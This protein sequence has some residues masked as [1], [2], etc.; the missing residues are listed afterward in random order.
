MEAHAN[1]NRI[2]LHALESLDEQLGLFD[3]LA[4]ADQIDMLRIA[5]RD[6]RHL[7]EIFTNLVDAYLA[8][9]LD[10]IYR[11]LE[12]QATGQTARL[13]SFFSDELIDRRNQ[14]MVERMQVRLAEG[15]ALIAVGALRLPGEDGLLRLLERRGFSI[16]RMD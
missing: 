2:A 6:S 4:P 16:Q 13:Q 15:N 8:R 5:V 3:R 1:A 11:L 14:R 7:D 10:A 9:D 12:E